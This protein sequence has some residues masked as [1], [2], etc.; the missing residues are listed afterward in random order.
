[1]SETTD[2]LLE[3][4]RKLERRVARMRTSLILLAVTGASV[5]TLGLTQGTVADGDRVV[6][7]TRFV[8]LDNDGDERAILG[9][10]KQ[11]VGLFM[12]PKKPSK[13]EKELLFVGL[14]RVEGLPTIIEYA[15][16]DL[17]SQVTPD[18]H[19]SINANA[20][21]LRDEKED[22]GIHLRYFKSP[23]LEFVDRSGL[24]YVELSHN[25]KDGT[26][27]SIRSPLGIKDAFKE[28]VEASIEKRKA[29][30]RIEE[31]W[32][33]SLRFDCRVPPF[34]DPDITLWKDGRSLWSAK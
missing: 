27:F 22:N 6:R 19:A 21:G 20:I 11:A 25:D 5:M 30:P 3:S 23:T 4:V 16:A 31:A 9:F 28:G 10:Q 34:S 33:K 17:Y 8:L 29:D 13:D 12:L 14:E 2:I 24:P 26:S 18:V 15:R 1:M 32:Q 7:A